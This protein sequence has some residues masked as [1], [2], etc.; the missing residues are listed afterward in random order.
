MRRSPHVLIAVLAVATATIALAPCYAGEA[1]QGK[2]AKVPTIRVIIDHENHLALVP[3]G[4]I[5]PSGLRL[6]ATRG[7][8]PESERGDSI[9]LPAQRPLV[10]SYAPVERF[11][12]FADASDVRVDAEDIEVV[13][14]E[15]DRQAQAAASQAGCPSEVEIE[16][17]PGI[18]HHLVCSYPLDPNGRQMQQV[19]GT[20]TYPTTALQARMYWVKHNSNGTTSTWDPANCV[21]S[22][23]EC[24]SGVA[25]YLPISVVSLDAKAYVRLPGGCNQNPPSCPIYTSSV[26]YAIGMP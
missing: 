15:G 6:F 2:D 21:P 26:T 13:Q 12:H 16:M 23:G 5:V 4:T 8:E 3:E 22:A 25:F 20:L 19:V 1:L 18:V 10:F 7:V 17:G 11:S 14:A 24:G 9:P